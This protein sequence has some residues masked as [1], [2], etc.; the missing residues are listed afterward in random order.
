MV[1]DFND[2]KVALWDFEIKVGGSLGRRSFLRSAVVTAIGI[3]N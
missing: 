1:L 3:S 2:S